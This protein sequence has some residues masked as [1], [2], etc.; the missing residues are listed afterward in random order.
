MN[1]TTFKVTGITCT[2]CATDI[3]TVLGNTDGVVNASVNYSTGEIAVEYGPDVINEQQVVR[4]LKNM[5]LRVQEV[6]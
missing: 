3:E 2:G 6:F 5:G 1:R 4:V